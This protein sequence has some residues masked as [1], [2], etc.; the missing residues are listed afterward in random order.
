MSGEPVF[1]WPKKI[2]HPSINKMSAPLSIRTAWLDTTSGAVKF[3]GESE[4][5]ILAYNEQNRLWSGVPASTYLSQQQGTASILP[6]MIE[7]VSNN[8]VFRPGTNS[9]T[10]YLIGGGSNPGDKPISKISTNTLKIN[11]VSTPNDPN[12][13]FSL[14]CDPTFSNSPIKEWVL[15]SAN[16]LSGQFLKTIGNGMLPNSDPYTEKL[17]WDWA[18]TIEINGSGNITA[19]LDNINSTDTHKIWNLSVAGTSGTVTSITPG[20]GIVTS[21]GP[22]N[23]PITSAGVMALDNTF[24][25]VGPTTIS[26]TILTGL[27]TTDGTGRIKTIQQAPNIPQTYLQFDSSGTLVP[28][29]LTYDNVTFD[30]LIQTAQNPGPGFNV[31]RLIDHHMFPQN[32]DSSVPGESTADFYN[33]SNCIVTGLTC[34]AN[35]RLNMSNVRVLR[36]PSGGNGKVVG[37]DGAGNI[38]WLD[39]AAGP[40]PITIAQGQG[41][42]VSGTSAYT[43]TNSNQAALVNG[44]GTVASV[45]SVSGDGFTKNWK[46]DNTQIAVVE[47]GTGMRVTPTVRPDGVTYLV[48]QFGVIPKFVDTPTVIVNEDPLATPGFVTYSLE[49]ADISGTSSGTLPFNLPQNKGVVSGL[50]ADSYGRLT[51]AYSTIGSGANKIKEYLSTD[52]GNNV[53]WKQPNLSELFDVLLTGAVSGDTIVYDGTKWVNSAGALTNFVTFQNNVN[54]TGLPP[55]ELRSTANDENPT[56]SDI[57]GTRAV[58]SWYSWRNFRSK[59]CITQKL[60]GHNVDA[61]NAGGLVSADSWPTRYGNVPAVGGGLGFWRIGQTTANNGTLNA[62]WQYTLDQTINCD[63]SVYSNGYPWLPKNLKTSGGIWSTRSIADA[64]SSVDGSAVRS[65]GFTVDAELTFGQIGPCRIGGRLVLVGYEYGSM[66]SSETW[67]SFHR[68]NPNPWKY[69][70]YSSGIDPTAP[71]AD[72]TNSGIPMQFIPGHWEQTFGDGDMRTCRIHED[73]SAWGTKDIGATTGGLEWAV[74]FEAVAL[75]GSSPS[76]VRLARVPGLSNNGRILG[77]INQPL[78]KDCR[79]WRKQRTTSNITSPV[80]DMQPNPFDGYNMD[81]GAPGFQVQTQFHIFPIMSLKVTFYA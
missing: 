26:G 5:N 46:V 57:T 31:V 30:L 3:P 78:G 72:Q 24:F 49:S 80:V 68:L 22:G 48:E 32:P 75:D 66:P 25:G 45:A 16:G 21:P 37:I 23:S 53:V 39:P 65:S 9:I 4:G 81:L 79:M 61:Y 69:D 43:I 34:Y 77:T 15:P 6:W 76:E 60:M 27:Q 1:Y 55:T 17:V 14:R 42:N 29:S 2:S 51:K 40:T 56:I 71:N 70:G 12:S 44:I 47:A 59:F 54:S 10:S 19:T 62:G 35:G 58:R 63:R 73:Y 64:I 33:P 8:S 18:P 50:T 28:A 52:S 13:G 11:D 7:T 38:N 67:S 41:I 74:W 36:Q 20:L